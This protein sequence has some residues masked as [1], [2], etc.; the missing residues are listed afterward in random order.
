VLELALPGR[1]FVALQKLGFQDLPEEHDR[2]FQFVFKWRLG[3]DFVREQ[4][5][6]VTAFTEGLV[7]FPGKEAV[8]DR[9]TG[10]FG[11]EGQIYLEHSQVGLDFGRCRTPLPHSGTLDAETQEVM[12]ATMPVAAHG[13]LHECNSKKVEIG[14]WQIRRHGWSRRGQVRLAVMVEI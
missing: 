8:A 5:H 14:G 13:G 6:D 3:V 9:I 2:R 7:F 11:H 12:D 1:P 4:Y 10:A